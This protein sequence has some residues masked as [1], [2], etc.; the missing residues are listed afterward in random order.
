M[1]K[2]AEAGQEIFHY[3]QGSAEM[4]KY[5]WFLDGVRAFL[6]LPREARLVVCL[7]RADC[8]SFRRISLGVG[9]VACERKALWVYR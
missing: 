3:T 5:C 1:G 8:L 4:G 6:Y 2:A 7:E 9:H